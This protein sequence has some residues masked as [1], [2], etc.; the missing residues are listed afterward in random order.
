[1]VSLKANVALCLA[2]CEICCRFRLDREIEEKLQFGKPLLIFFSGSTSFGMGFWDSGFLF[3][4]WNWNLTF[5][6]LKIKF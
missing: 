3:K 5:L 4:K 2:Q 6:L 1:V